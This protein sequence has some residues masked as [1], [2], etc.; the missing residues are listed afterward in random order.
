V[1]SA[2]VS[3]VEPSARRV[4]A[5]TKL[6]VWSIV[7]EPLIYFVVVTQSVSGIGGN[8]S[9]IAQAIVI[10]AMLCRV[11]L[12]TGRR[13]GRIRFVRLTSPLYSNYAAY[14]ALA[15]L[16][17]IVGA[18]SGAY[19]I[20]GASTDVG[21]AA[22]TFL[23][24]AAVRPLLEYVIAAYYFIYFAI[25]PQY[26]ITTKAAAAYFFRVFRLMLVACLVLG[27]LDLVVVLAT[28]NN[29]LSRE[30]YDN[31]SVGFRFH[32][33]AGEPRDAFV[34]MFLALAVL[35]LEA[36]TRGAELRKRWVVI[37]VTAA[38]LTQSASGLLGLL[39]FIGL[40]VVYSLPRM[41][42]LRVVQLTLIS[43]AVGVIVYEAVVHSPRLM[44]YVDAA[45]GIWSAFES[46]TP[47]PPAIALQVTSFFPIFELWVK[48]RHFDWLPVLI[49]SGL[50]SSSAANT[51]YVT[52]GAQLANP[53]SQIVRTAYESG[54]IGMIFF[55][56]A[57]TR[58][59]TYLTRGLVPKR[60]NQFLIMTLAL[61]G[62]FLAHRSSA[63][64]IYVGVVIA[65]FRTLDEREIAPVAA[66]T[67][68]PAPVPELAPTA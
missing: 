30:L 41:R 58:P 47:L 1:V 61:V 29:L 67:Y 19:T 21:S 8:I 50:G 32:G 49:G 60:R 43:A 66:G 36:Y 10:A 51:Y 25:L 13:A 39:F 37:C 35:H 22:A 12:A 14:F 46:G 53:A 17:G 16:A 18:F 26:F 31:T 68:V 57:F 33:I 4:P 38:L 59:I 7:L 15:V 24:S 63:P 34:Y 5:L 64:F 9:R 65:V 20:A 2:D 11:A 55:L 44:R 6:F 23:N 42:P 52:V 27:S 45:S 48:L 28:G 56:R 54:I 40:Y 62:C 3:P